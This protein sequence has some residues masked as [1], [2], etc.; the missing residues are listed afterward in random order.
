M[1]ASFDIGVTS[2][3]VAIKVLTAFFTLLLTFLPLAQALFNPGLAR[4][5]AVR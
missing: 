1:L 2:R 5:K 3:Y 4:W